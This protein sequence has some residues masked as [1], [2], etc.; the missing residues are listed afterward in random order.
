[1]K[2]QQ[3]KRFFCILLMLSSMYA[4]AVENS[5]FSPQTFGH[6]FFSQRP[7]W[8]NLARRLVG[9]T[10]FLVP[11]DIDC[12][13]G[14]LSFTPEYIRSFDRDE[15]GK[16][17]F[18][19]GTNMMTFGAAGATGV[20]VFARNFFLND[21][22][23]G[24]VTALPRV[25][26]ALLDIDFRLNLDEWVCGLY[27][28]IHAP[29]TWS[30]WTVNLT[31]NVI[32]TGTYIETFALGNTSA[33]SSPVLSILAAFNGQQ[34]DTTDFPDLKQVLQ[35]GRVDTSDAMNSQTPETTGQQTRTRLADVEVA[36]GYNILC[37]E[38]YHLGFDARVVFPSSNRPNAMFL[39]EPVA[40]N[41]KHYE[42]GGGVS[43]HYEFWNNCCDSSFAVWAEADFYTVLKGRQR[44]IFDLKNTDS[45]QNVGSN[46]L[47][48]KRF[49]GAPADPVLAEILY[50][51]NVLALNC[52]VRNS[53]HVEAAVLF[54]YYRCGF[55][56]DAGYNVWSR[57]KD[58]IDHIEQI[59]PNTYGLAGQTLGTGS[60]TANNTGSTAQINGT[61]GEPDPVNIYLSNDQLC[62]C[63]A[64]TPRSI[65]H[66]FFAHASYAWE[67]CDYTPF[68]GLGGEVEF[69][70]NKN[71][72]FDQWGLW[73]KG[74]FAF[75]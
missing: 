29:V 23:N 39:F 6:T 8:S 65:S 22:F 72:A 9:V 1:M 5:C 2:Q 36:F 12:L 28:E 53:L 70:G 49:T 45:T 52:K 43:T 61:G 48:I 73:I 66:K 51:P 4:N 40:G 42:V 44:R 69:S 62:I 27:F 10:E 47:L 13:N 24:I 34:L 38:C 35:F 26:N 14:F 60:T 74:G 31:E 18:F 50:G 21:N 46:R 30:S 3:L 55:T 63:S 32:T 58:L 20:D 67:N 41:G 68:L 37:G 15:I 11:C 19:N 56:L 17:F 59:P 75:S 57:S 54:D 7:Q 16:Y 71:S 64:A 25:E 33:I